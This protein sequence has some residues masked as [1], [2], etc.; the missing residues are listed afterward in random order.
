MTPSA[1][2]ALNASYPACCSESV[3]SLPALWIEKRLRS[4]LANWSSSANS[5]AGPSGRGLALGP[6]EVSAASGATCTPRHEPSVLRADTRSPGG[7]LAAPRSEA[8][9]CEAE[10]APLP[11][12]LRAE[13]RMDPERCDAAG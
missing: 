9:R 3:D 7:V 8:E 11:T 12:S 5:M 10:A 13:T 4:E 6:S 1:A 2:T